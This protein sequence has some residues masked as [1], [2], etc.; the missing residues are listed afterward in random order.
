[1]TFKANVEKHQRLS[2]ASVNFH[3]KPLLNMGPSGIQCTY[4]AYASVVLDRV[5]RFES[6]KDF[7][8]FASSNLNQQISRPCLLTRKCLFLFSATSLL[9]EIEFGNGNFLACIQ[10]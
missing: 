6:Q 8:P 5:L 9:I 10:S 1:M 7:C 3:Q 4:I 2:D